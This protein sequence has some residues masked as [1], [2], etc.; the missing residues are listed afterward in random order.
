[1]GAKNLKKFATGGYTGSRGAEPVGNVHEGF[2]VPSGVFGVREEPGKLP[3]IVTE[4][5]P[6]TV[7]DL[8]ED[9]EVWFVANTDSAFEAMNAVYNHVRPHY[10]AEE[11]VEWESDMSNLSTSKESVW[12]ATGH[13]EGEMVRVAEETPPTVLTGIYVR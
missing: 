3:T 8:G 7:Y 11:M 4:A 5:E 6:V 12:F 9:N 13:Y 1:M 10:T 2:T